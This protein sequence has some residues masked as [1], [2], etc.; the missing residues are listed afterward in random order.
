MSVLISVHRDGVTGSIQLSIG[1]AHGG[2]RIAGPK[3]NGTGRLLLEHMVTERDAQEI[4]SY[5]DKATHP[6]AP[7]TALSK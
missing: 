1:N 2:Y 4:R 6:T 7:K 3:F 5:L